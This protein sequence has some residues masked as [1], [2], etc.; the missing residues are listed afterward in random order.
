VNRVVVIARDNKALRRLFFDDVYA[1]ATDS[2]G[3]AALSSF[4]TPAFS[5]FIWRHVSLACTKGQNQDGKLQPSVLSMN[6]I[7]RVPCTSKGPVV[8]RSVFLPI[9]EN[10]IHLVSR[11]SP[12]NATLRKD[13]AQW[14]PLQDVHLIPSI[15]EREVAILDS[16]HPVQLR[17]VFLPQHIQRDNLSLQDI[18]R[19][20]NTPLWWSHLINPLFG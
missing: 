18:P 5:V 14:Y 19:L 8:P 20:P 10:A 3:R 7:F 1:H 12:P 13:T 4:A 9:P 11:E 15:N 16:G 6:N 2:L 17:L